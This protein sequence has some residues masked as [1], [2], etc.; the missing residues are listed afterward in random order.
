MHGAFDSDLSISVYGPDH[1]QEIHK[2]LHLKLMT[3]AQGFKQ[4]NMCLKRGDILN[5]NM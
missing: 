2:N 5:H 3:I 1:C 4:L